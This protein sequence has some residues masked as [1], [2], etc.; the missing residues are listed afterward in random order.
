MYNAIDIH[1]HFGDPSCFPQKGLEKEFMRLD[2]EQLKAEYDRQQIS[3][4][5]LS[6]MEAIFPADEIT[7]LRANDYMAELA[8]TCDWLY[9]W[10]VVDPLLPASYQQAEALLPERKCA[11]VKIHP[12]AHGYPIREWG[13]EIF[14]FCQEHGAVLETHSGEP[15]SMPEDMVPFADKYPGVRVIAAHLGFGSDGCVEHQVRAIQEAKHGN[16]YTDVSSSRSILNHLVEWAVDQVTADKLLFG[17]D[18][19]LHHIAMMKQ[20]VEYA[21]IPE[22]AKEAIFH[23]SA[24]RL[25]GDRLAPC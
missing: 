2:L 4:A 11:G 13:D 3:A 21:N 8:R 18:T 25:L 12:D 24:L 9:Q 19:P 20:R 14:A 1:G 15:M 17:T 22:A 16:I 10:V 6:P 7:L 5:C 23:G